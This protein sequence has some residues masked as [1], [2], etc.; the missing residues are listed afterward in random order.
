MRK[1]V[2]EDPQAVADILNR[3]EYASLALVDD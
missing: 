3:A 2:T 1:D